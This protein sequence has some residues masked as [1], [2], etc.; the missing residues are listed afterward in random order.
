MDDI[1]RVAA[2]LLVK[3]DRSHYGQ[4]YELTGPEAL[5]RAQI[6]E[7]IGV[8]IGVDVTFEQCSRA[9][10]EEALRPAMGDE[11]GLVSRP[12]GRRR[13]RASAGQSVGGRAHRNPGR[14]GRAVGGAQRRTVPLTPR[15]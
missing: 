9:E 2:A 6:A 15:R 8:G 7:Q 3:P 1:A 13:R 4:I 11:V 14:I 12:D 5:T 10:A